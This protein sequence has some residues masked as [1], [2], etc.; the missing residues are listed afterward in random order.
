[1]TSE[2]QRP[3]SLKELVMIPPV[4]FHLSLGPKDHLALFKL[5]SHC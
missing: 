2:R 5:P 1:M 3:G 4:S